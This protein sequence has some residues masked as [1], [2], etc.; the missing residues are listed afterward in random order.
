MRAFAV[1]LVLAVLSLVGT[2]GAA[3]AQAEGAGKGAPAAAAKQELVDLNSATADQLQ[4]LPGI[5]EAYSKKI[6]EGRPY[7]KK[8]QL[9]S[10]KIVPRATYDKIKDRVIAKQPAGGAAPARP[11]KKP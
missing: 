1:A 3:L 10:R 7:A 11:D 2:P 9:V 8:D 6:I 4:A 5:G